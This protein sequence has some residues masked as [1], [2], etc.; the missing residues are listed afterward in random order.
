MIIAGFL[1]GPSPWPSP[2]SPD[3]A[4]LPKHVGGYGERFYSELLVTNAPSGSFS[5]LWLQTFSL[6]PD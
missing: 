5:Q 4:G 2:A 6:A 3:L 1:I